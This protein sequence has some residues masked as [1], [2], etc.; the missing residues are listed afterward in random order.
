MFPFACTNRENSL[1]KGELYVHFKLTGKPIEPALV[2][3]V[4]LEL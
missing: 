4:G 3:W 2:D 1:L